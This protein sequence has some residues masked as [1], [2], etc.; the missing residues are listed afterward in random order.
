MNPLGNPNPNGMLITVP[1]AAY[2]SNLSIKTTRRLAKEAGA[3]LK[4]GGASRVDSEKY[5]AY[6]CNTYAE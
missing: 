2:E 6:I 5:F 3:F 1:Q 4:I